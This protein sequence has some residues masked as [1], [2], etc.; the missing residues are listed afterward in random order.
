MHQESEVRVSLGF[1]PARPRVSSV[2]PI[3]A[4]PGL[5]HGSS[6][7]TVESSAVTELLPTLSSGSLGLGWLLALSHPTL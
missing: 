4:I 7:S 3:P 5:V 1:L 2:V 6:S